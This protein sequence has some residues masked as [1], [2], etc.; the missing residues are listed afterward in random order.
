MNLPILGLL[1]TLVAVMILGLTTDD[2]IRDVC[3]RLVLDRKGIP[4]D[5]DYCLPSGA[6][7]QRRM[8]PAPLWKEGE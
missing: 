2:H 4:C 5:N 1:A 6:D 7:T 3:Q 8:A